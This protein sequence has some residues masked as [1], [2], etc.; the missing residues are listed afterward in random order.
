MWESEQSEPQKASSSQYMWALR[1]H[2]PPGLQSTSHLFLS[3]SMRELHTRASKTLSPQVQAQALSPSHPTST[4]I[5]RL[6]Q[7]GPG[8]W[9]LLPGMC[10]SFGW[11][12]F[13]VSQSSSFTLCGGATV[14]QQA[15][16]V[17]LMGL[18]VTPTYVWFTKGHFF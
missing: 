15:E 17:P 5:C 4:L 8:I 18:K 16:E 7:F 6:P 3:H 11:A 10:Y 14:Q 1:T 12:F 9:N 13:C 2:G